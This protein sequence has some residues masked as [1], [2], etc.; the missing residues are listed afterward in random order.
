MTKMWVLTSLSKMTQLEKH[1]L[2]I[3]PYSDDSV[4]YLH[5]VCDTSYI[6]KDR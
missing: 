6:I 4:P 2:Y 1:E 5:S 3:H